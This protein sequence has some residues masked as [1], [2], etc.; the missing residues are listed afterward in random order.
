[1]Q[2]NTLGAEDGSGAGEEDRGGGLEEEERLLGGCVVE[3][4]DVIAK[5][6]HVVSNCGRKREATS[7]AAVGTPRTRGDMKTY[8]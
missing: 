4:S 3:F 5:L 1:V 2:A 7:N 6:V 8:A